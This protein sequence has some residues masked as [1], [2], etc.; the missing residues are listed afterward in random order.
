VYCNISRVATSKPKKNRKS[1]HGPN[2]IH[3]SKHA[4]KRSKRGTLVDR[5]ANGGI[6]GNDAKVIFKC[7]TTVDVTGIDNHELNALPMVDATAKT[8]TDKG[9]VILILRNYA[10]HGLNRTLHSTGQIEWYQNKAHDTSMRVGGRQVIKTVD[11]YYIPINVIRGLP[12]IQMEPNTAEEFD[13]LPHV[14]LTQ[15][16]EWDPTVLDHI[17]TDDDDWV[18]KVKREEDQEHDSPFD[19]RGEYKHREPVR[20]GVPIE[21]PT[22]P[23][24]ED[25]DDI[26]VNLH[27]GNI[28]VNFHADDA[29]R[30]VHQAYQEVL[31][32]TRY[33]FMRAKACLMMKLKLLKKKRMRPKKTSKRILLQWRPS[34]NQSTTPSIEGNSYMCQSKRSRGHSLLRLRMQLPLYMGPRQT[35]LSSLQILHSTFAEERKQ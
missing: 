7:N 8:I 33:L 6:L 3:A 32:S 21:N 31:T 27:S 29:T 25:P 24:S 10:Y 34:R 4:I 15:G 1:K 35:K 14:I 2:K 17:L 16:G 30:E 9:P 23:P 12:H 22:G 26:E 19:N 13:T 18:S 5:G 11:G 20:A 28:E